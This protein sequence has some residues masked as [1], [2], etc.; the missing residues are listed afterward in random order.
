VNAS[1]NQSINH[2]RPSRLSIS[3]WRLPVIETS[4]STSSPGC[5]ARIHTQISDSCS[6]ALSCTA[7]TVLR[8]LDGYVHI[9]MS[10][11]LG[12]PGWAGIHQRRHKAHA[13]V[14]TAGSR[15]WPHEHD[16]RS[17][18]IAI[19]EHVCD[20]QLTHAAIRPPQSDI[21]RRQ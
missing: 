10:P 9:C 6:A 4:T 13:Y 8:V 17:S 12:A 5:C 3:H 7:V 20:L 15:S 16:F 21:C 14:H 1:C 11:G 2:R 19:F 18:P